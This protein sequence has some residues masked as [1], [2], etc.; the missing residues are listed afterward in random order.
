MAV[1]VIIFYFFYGFRVH[2]YYNPGGLEQH[3]AS[4]A[5]VRRVDQSSPDVSRTTGTLISTHC[6]TIHLNIVQQRQ[7]CSTIHTS[8][9]LQQQQLWLLNIQQCEQLKAALKNNGENQIIKIS[10]HCLT[11]FHLP[12]FLEPGIST[13][14][15][16]GKAQK[17]LQIL[18]NQQQLNYE[19]SCKAISQNFA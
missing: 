15:C 8:N 19:K 12:S 10:V 5:Q 13:K 18:E 6:S 4:Q 16:C 9:I 1:Y 17:S 14:Y 3:L 11:E 7:H 2:Y